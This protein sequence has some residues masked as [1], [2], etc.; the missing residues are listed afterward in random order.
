MLRWQWLSQVPN[1][2]EPLRALRQ[3]HLLWR[4][5][6]LARAWT[7]H[8][9]TRCMAVGSWTTECMRGLR[10]LV[11]IQVDTLNRHIQPS[12]VCRWRHT[13]LMISVCT[14]LSTMWRRRIPSTFSTLLNSYLQWLRTP[15]TTG[16]TRP[17][18]V[19][20]TMLV[21]TISTMLRGR[22]MPMQTLTCLARIGS[23][24]T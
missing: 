13:T 11:S 14:T 16:T 9:R 22:D 3:I 17:I 4:S 6:G 18:N 7:W 15:S 2:T 12:G 24:D 5:E 23:I 10:L 20:Y 8:L 19:P 1:S 21:P